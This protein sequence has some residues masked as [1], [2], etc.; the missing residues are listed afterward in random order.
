MR[1]KGGGRGGV[2]KGSPFSAS[3]FLND[4]ISHLTNSTQVRWNPFYF[5]FSRPI[6]QISV[7]RSS[8][9]TDTYSILSAWPIDRSC[10]LVGALRS[11]WCFFLARVH[12][13]GSVLFY[14]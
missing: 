3:L 6:D 13:V 11:E 2:G 7:S 12:W 5:F 4:D 14:N 9:N 8:S 10:T 1:W